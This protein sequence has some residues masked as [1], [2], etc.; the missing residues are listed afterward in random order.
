VAVDYTI[1]GI[2]YDG[3]RRERLHVNNPALVFIY[4]IATFAGIAFAGVCLVFN[5]TFR[6]RR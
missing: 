5:I 6:N 2:P 3:R 4:S 1:G